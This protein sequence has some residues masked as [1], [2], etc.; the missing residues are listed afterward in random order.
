MI[1]AE[2][3]DS[4]KVNGSRMAIV[5]I[6]AMPGSTPTSVPIK[7]PSRQKPRLAGVSAVA[8]PVARPPIRSMRAAASPRPDRYRHAECHHEQD[9]GK[10]GHRDSEQDVLDRARIGG[11]EPGAND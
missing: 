1:S 10:G 5:E 9:D 2:A 3:G 4:E 11:G 8:K 6:G 7:A